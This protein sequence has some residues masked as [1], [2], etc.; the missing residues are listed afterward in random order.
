MSI[1][2]WQLGILILFFF[3]SLIALILCLIL[4]KKKN[5]KKIPKN[6][7][8]AGFWHRFLAYLIDFIIL[9]VIYFILTL[10][11]IIGWIIAIFFGWLY[12]AI[13]HSSTKRST[14]GMRALDITINDENLDKIGFWR[15][16]GN[17][18]VVGISVM[19]LFIGLIMIGF[20][21]R[22]QGLHNL[23]SRT[24]HLKDK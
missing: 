20:T 5:Y 8:Y 17:Y 1:G 18:L 3:P 10:I 9:A 7:I 4:I 2:F 11:P 14:L 23:V 15:A 21:S 19:I 16:T 22:K 13:Q 12:F 6:K 24:I